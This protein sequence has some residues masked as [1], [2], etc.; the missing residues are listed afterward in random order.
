MSD[1]SGAPVD[2]FLE[3]GDDLCEI[4]FFL[5]QTMLHVSTLAEDVVLFNSREF[6]LVEMD[7]RVATGSSIMPH[8]KNPD[9]CELLRAKSG[10]AVGRLVSLLAIRKGLPCS[11]AP[12]VPD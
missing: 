8:K 7:D 9:L 3:D 2:I 1:A 4:A 10:R 5:T 12:D 6:D 11:N